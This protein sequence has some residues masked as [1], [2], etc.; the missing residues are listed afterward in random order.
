MN[1]SQEPGRWTLHAT[2]LNVPDEEAVVLW[3]IGRSDNGVVRLGGGIHLREDL[4]RQSL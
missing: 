2:P 1:D 4:L 3:E